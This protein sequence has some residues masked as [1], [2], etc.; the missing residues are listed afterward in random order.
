MKADTGIQTVLR[1][2]RDVVIIILTVTAFT[3]HCTHATYVCSL[4]PSLSLLYAS[5]RT[6]I[7]AL[8]ALS[9]Q[10]LWCRRDVLDR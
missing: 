9:V 4:V 1:G 5:I 10:C 6:T 8:Y 7:D 2:R 3:A